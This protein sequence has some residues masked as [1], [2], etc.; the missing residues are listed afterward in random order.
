MAPP[1]VT[2]DSSPGS[3]DGA[4]SGLLGRDLVRDVGEPG[5]GGDWLFLPNELVA[6]R[7]VVRQFLGQGGMGQVFLAW[8]STL[9]Q[10]VALKAVRPERA[11][12]RRMLTRLRQEALL[13]RH[14][15]HPNVCRVFD[16][17]VHRPS[18]PER[19]PQATMVLAMELLEGPTLDHFLRQRGPLPAEEALP[20]ARDLAEALDAAHRVRILH[21]DLKSANVVL[22]RDESRG[23]PRAV[24]TDF[25]LARVQ[26]ARDTAVRGAGTPGYTAPE[27]LAGD[28]PGPA[29]DLYSFGVILHEMVAGERPGP[30]LSAHLPL[31]W[32]AV[33]RQCLSRRPE[34]R[35][36]SAGEAVEGLRERR[37]ALSGA[38]A[39]SRAALVTAV[40]GLA[41]AALL[42]L[43]PLVDRPLS[44]VHE[45]SASP[46]GSAQELRQRALDPPE[47]NPFR[48]YR[49]L[50]RFLGDLESRATFLNERA[51]F[52]SHRGRSGWSR[53]LWDEMLRL[54]RRAGLP[55]EEVVPMTNLALL[56]LNQGRLEPAA[57]QLRNSLRLW[58]RIGDHD[59]ITMALVHMA[60][61]E[62]LRGDA[63]AEGALLRETEA[64]TRRL[65]SRN[66]SI[67]N[68]ATAAPKISPEGHRSDRAHR[69][70]PA[71]ARRLSSQGRQDHDAAKRRP[72]DHVEPRG[73]LPHRAAH[74]RAAG[75]SDRHGSAAVKRRG[76]ELQHVRRTRHAGTSRW[77]RWSSKSRERLVEYGKRDVV[78]LLDSITRLARAYNT[79]VPSSGK[80][81]TGGVDANA[82]QRP[83]R[84]FGAARNIEEGGSL[85][86]VATAL[87]D[88]GSRMDDVIYEEFKGTGNSEIHME[89]KIAERRIFPSI[90]ID[91]SGT[92]RED[93]LV[94]AANL[95]KVWILRKLLAPMEEV[96]AIEFLIDRLKATKTNNEFFDAM[97]R[98]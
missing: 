62:A 82:L 63:E 76:R 24:V 35:L 79:V 26:G 41:V 37:S 73:V 81:L 19:E 77:P 14:V 90:N 91:R 4:S 30:R 10:E 85:T 57:G 58:R 2:W 87:V 52:Y 60:D 36:R 84:F 68:A 45:L 95:Q 20:L 3:L 31:R 96:A 54:A 97:R 12:D 46:G 34:R 48:R 61:V 38:P 33:L 23:G 80:V 98:Q 42:A 5:T 49:D 8:D 55:L 28:D 66:V 7:F 67:S 39:A 47:E 32:R 25:G 40:A 83:K 9:R 29:A 17:F 92:R 15:T 18:I 86:I 65:D 89:R 51:L 22:V 16:V 53:Q 94:N 59:A 21:L 1:T 72:L 88:T 74:R 50:S 70:G 44:G 43:G 6:E 11:G 78:I 75:R 56:D 71:R 69:Q 27:I 93:L 13:A 64:R